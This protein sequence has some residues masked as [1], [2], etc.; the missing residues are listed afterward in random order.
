M[1]KMTRRTRKGGDTFAGG[2]S[3]AEW[4]V[5]NAFPTGNLVELGPG[6]AEDDPACG[7]G[8]GPD[9]LVRARFLVSLLCGAVEVEPDLVGAVNIEGACVIGEAGVSGSQVQASA[10][11]E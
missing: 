5:L 2:L 7:E 8:W 9:R 10:A 1:W 4:R 3:D 6:N 11:I